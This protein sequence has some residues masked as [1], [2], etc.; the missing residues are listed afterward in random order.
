MRREISF[1]IVCAVIAA[2]LFPAAP[3]AH[4]E[5]TGNF[6]ESITWSL[7]DDGVLSIK[8]SGAMPDYT[9]SSQNRSPFY[10]D[11]SIVRVT[12][13]SGVTAIGRAM[14]AHCQNMKSIDIPKSV[15][16]IGQD[17]FFTCES[18]ADVFY[19]G[20]EKDWEAVEEGTRGESKPTN[21]TIHYSAALKEMGM[22]GEKVTWRL[23]T[24]GALEIDGS[25][26]IPDYSTSYGS[27]SPF[28]YNSSVRGIT[29]GEGVT[30]IG[31]SLFTGCQY[32]TVV[33]ISASVESVASGTFLSCSR[34]KEINVSSESEF[35]CSEDGVLFNKGKTTLIQ[36][37]TARGGEYTLPDS[38]TSIYSYAFNSNTGITGVTLPEGLKTIGACSFRNCSSL[39][40]LVIPSSVTSIGSEALCGCRS[41]TGILVD[42]GNTAYSDVDGVL[43]NKSGTTLIQCPIMR[44]GEYT[45]PGGVTSI[46]NSAFRSCSSL[47]AVDLPASVK[48]IGSE[49][50]CGCSKLGKINVD[51]E[52]PSYSSD[53]G[54]LFNKAGTSLIRCPSAYQGEYSVP[55]GVK[56]IGSHSFCN[57][58]G[59]SALSLPSGITSIG[60]YALSGCNK[61]REL[62][63]PEGVKTIGTCALESC[64]SL[65]ALALP[66]GVET[67]GS[68]A[69]SG[70]SSLTGLTLCCGVES[71]GSYAFSGCSK[72]TAF[73]VPAGVKTIGGLAFNSCRSMKEVNLPSSLKTVGSYAF[74]NCTALSVIR[75]GGTVQQWSTLTGDKIVVKELICNAPAVGVFGTVSGGVLSGYTVSCAPA[76]SSLIAASYDSR[77]I[78]LDIRVIP[79]DAGSSEGTVEGMKKGSRCALFLLG[80]NSVPLCQ[81]WVRFT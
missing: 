6:G 17:A 24:N 80:E 23:Y 51:P 78:L 74:N 3:E 76:G 54:V 45:V 30:R 50:F 63:I 60:S 81:E 44:T 72:L 41:L 27:R 5:S 9:F 59:L 64:S 18:L 16:R 48:S 70:C 14:F 38:V 47:T 20:D 26:P 62:A 57:C 37:P 79:L 1:F 36:F 58:S 55:D 34:L 69:F 10:H 52:S 66:R 32:A 77:G 42:D 61:L 11:Y 22:L 65:T 53:N 7:S 33:S 46:G 29:V 4:A 39:R 75:Y 12:I 8:G 31:G 13:G 49:S 56:S 15:V 35:L 28:Y 2:M 25:G 43:F 40:E 67:I 21:A 68:Y 73:T 19:G 71:I